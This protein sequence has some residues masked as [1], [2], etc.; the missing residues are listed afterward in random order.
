MRGGGRGLVVKGNSFDRSSL[1]MLQ[2]LDARIYKLRGVKFLRWSVWNITHDPPKFQK[3]KERKREAHKKQT[4]P[5]KF[6]FCVVSYLTR[7][8][9]NIIIFFY[10]PPPHPCMRGGSHWL[11]VEMRGNSNPFGMLNW[12][13][14]LSVSFFFHVCLSQVRKRGWGLW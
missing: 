11:C 2:S 13:S 14:L 12:P 10:P 3:K 9:H 5:S 1:Q 7:E 4:D 8:F 6:L